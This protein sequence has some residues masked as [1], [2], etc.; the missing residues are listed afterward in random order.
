MN[1]KEKKLEQYYFDIP[2]CNENEIFVLH[3][4]EQQEQTEVHI[5][6]WNGKPVAKLYLDK[7]IRG[8]DVDV[9][10]NYLFGIEELTECLYKF[11]LKKWIR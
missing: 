10:Q 5:I 1:T 6:N 9:S 8:L 7:K 3:H 4:S 11:D 2:Y